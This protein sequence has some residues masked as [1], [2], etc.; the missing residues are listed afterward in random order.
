MP[1]E[2]KSERES[3]SL[4]AYTSAENILLL[5]DAYKRKNGKEDEAKIIFGKASSAYT[6]TKS[7]LRTFGLINENDCEFTTLGRNVAYSEEDEKKQELLHVITSYLPYESIL[8]NIFQ[9]GPINETEIKTITNFWGKF[10]KGS[11]QRNLAEAAYLFGSMV[12]YVGLGTYKIGRKGKS[13]RIEWEA[14]ANEIFNKVLTDKDSPSDQNENGIEIP[15]ENIEETFSILEPINEQKTVDSTSTYEQPEITHEI[16]D[17]K[18]VTPTFI[19]KLS[20]T[21]NI[22]INVDMSDWSEEKIKNFFKCAYGI[23]EEE[24]E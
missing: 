8:A 17:D 4:P 14:D 12:E 11:T 5:L 9:K 1:K 19:P 16:N 6:N 3:N 22:T 24:T 23:F 21:P 18:I 20:I 7:A 15:V 2:D 10:G 13:S